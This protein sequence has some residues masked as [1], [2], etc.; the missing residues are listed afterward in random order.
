MKKRAGGKGRREAGTVN[1]MRSAFKQT[2]RSAGEPIR[3]ERDIQP[4]GRRTRMLK[5]REK[6]S[7]KTAPERFSDNH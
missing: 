7:K 2:Q 4:A 5:R 3:F 1:R 6:Q